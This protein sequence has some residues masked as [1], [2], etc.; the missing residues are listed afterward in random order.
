MLAQANAEI[1]ALSMASGPPD[2]LD[3]LTDAYR[4]LEWV[5]TQLEIFHLAGKTRVPDSFKARLQAT[6]EL[7]PAPIEPPER[8]NALIRRTIDQCFALQEEIKDEIH[9]LEDDSR[10]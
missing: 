9:R 7:L 8:W 2:Q 3:V 10:S 5:I 1:A 4:H 6:N